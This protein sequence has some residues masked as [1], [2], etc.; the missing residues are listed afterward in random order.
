MSDLIPINSIDVRPSG[1][2]DVAHRFLN[3]LDVKP[4]SRKT[5]E[6]GLKQFIEWFA[7]QAISNPKRENILAY[8][9]YLQSKGI[10]ALTV[11]SYLVAVRRFFEFAEAEKIYP[12]IA[13]N[14]KGCKRAKS[15]RKD[16]LTLE[17]AHLLLGSFDLSLRDEL[18]NFAM[19]N[20]LLRAGLRTI[21]LVR[22]DLKD[23]SQQSGEA[24]LWI[25]GKNCDSKDQF[26]VLTEASLRPIRDYLSSRGAIKETDPLFTSNSDRNKNDRLSTR[27][28]SR[29]VKE[30]LKKIGIQDPRITAHSLRHTAIT[31]ALKGGATIQEAQ[32]LGRH[33][34]IN[35]TLVYAHNSHRVQNAAEKK[36]DA[37]LS[38]GTDGVT[39]AA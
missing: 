10:S 12:N 18:R 31:L 33:Q 5:Y 16:P 27:S 24:V 35:T 25:Q 21:E 2:D 3:S 1:L 7:P 36:I 29:I 19:I 9:D 28:I 38:R 23:I 6:R 32:A 8:K 37:I 15:F 30:Q 17:Q 11:S 13:K 4:N 34:S 22:A 14:V 20:L 39:Q 26:V